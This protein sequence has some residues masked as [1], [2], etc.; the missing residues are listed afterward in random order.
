MAYTRTL[1]SGPMTEPSRAEESRYMSRISI[2]CAIEAGRLEAQ[3]L[4]MLRTL[5]QF[6]GAL[7]GAPVTAL[8]GRRGAPL[9][10]ATHAALEEMDVAYAYRPDL[11]DAPWF[12]FT[13]KIA[14]VRYAEEHYQT[15]WRLWL[16]SDILFLNEPSFVND[17]ALDT[18]D[19]HAR[20]EFRPP[21]VTTTDQTFVPYWTKLCALSGLDFDSLPF[22]DLDIPPRRMKPAFN[23]GVFL[24]RAGTGFVETYTKHYHQL[25]DA[26]ISPKGLGPWFADQVIMAPVL[27]AA[28]LQW[29]MLSVEDHLM[30]FPG[31]DVPELPAVMPRANLVHYSKSRLAPHREAF[32]RL[33]LDSHPR[34]QDLMER[35]DREVAPT[36][37]SL[38]ER[39]IRYPRALRLHYFAR[40]CTEV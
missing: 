22:Y 16:D 29:R 24:W 20:L 8:Q 17:P 1:R 39:L 11:N 27:E 33:V 30:L 6:G 19:F 15:P 5:R 35:H 38:T 28:K 10:K 9:R 3:T 34:L 37:N 36:T 31:P 26:R 7:A 40:R 4:L 14:A 25:L 21:A 2:V 12:N 18:A 13:N 32:D 23:S